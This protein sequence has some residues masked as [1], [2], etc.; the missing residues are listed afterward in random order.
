MRIAILVV[1]LLV[2]WASPVAGRTL[3]SY[4]GNPFTDAS[5]ACTTVDRVTAT[6]TLSSRVPPSVSPATDYS[7]QVIAY[8][9]SAC[10]TTCTSGA[11]CP[12]FPF[13]V[14]LVST[15]ATGDV[16]EWAVAAKDSPG[17]T[18]IVDG[19]SSERDVGSLT[20]DAFSVASS[21]IA[22]NLDSPGTWTIT[23]LPPTTVRVFATADTF[24]G[25]LGSLAGADAI[26]NAQ[27][28]QAG[29]GGTWV[30]W[31]STTGVD[32]RDRLPVGSGPFVRAVSGV[33][34][35]DDLF[36]LANAQLDA[37]VR[38]DP[39]GLDLGGQRVWTGTV[40]LGGTAHPDRCGDWTDELEDGMTGGTSSIGVGWTEQSLSSQCTSPRHL[41][42]LELPPASLPALG[43]VGAMALVAIVEASG[44]GAARLARRRR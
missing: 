11:P 31:L 2:W 37:P 34:I 39:F 19:I 33:Q 42:C 14:F 41:Y 21:A 13:G 23:D 7:D 29:L 40:G 26:C 8:S 30:A 15:D 32:A 10:G 25:D 16:D 3:Y 38:D 28:A 1:P 9:V 6:F 18:P 12:G 17:F 36:D 4:Q 22:Y 27:A 24:T 35:A 44:A 43:D 5:G 20:V